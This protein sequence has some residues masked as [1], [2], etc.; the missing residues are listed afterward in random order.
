MDNQFPCQWQAAWLERRN[1]AIFCTW[2]GL[3]SYRGEA[4]TILPNSKGHNM[5]KTMTSSFAAFV[6]LFLTFATVTFVHVEAATAATL[7]KG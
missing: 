5:R 1:S 7:V 2:H 4:G 3:C 6:S